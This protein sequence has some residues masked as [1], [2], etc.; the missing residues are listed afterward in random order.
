MPTTAIRIKGSDTTKIECKQNFN[1]NFTLGLMISASGSFP[2]LLLIGKGK[3]ERCLKKYDIN[4]SV[5]GT[6]TNNGWADEKCILIILNEVAKI[7]K[8]EESVLLMDNFRSHLTDN[9]KNDAKLKNI[10]LVYV[11]NGLT[12]KYQPLDI[13]ING[14]LKEKAIKMYCEFEAKN[15]TLIYD[16]KQCL[17]DILKIK[18]TITKK[19]II[20]SFDCL[21]IDPK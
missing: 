17:I 3:T 12:S 11:P 7:T 13:C 1:E 2:K 6:Y 14:I 21:K 8:N 15:S 5:I 18:K 4:D 20:H 16:H 10:N 19:T 9:V